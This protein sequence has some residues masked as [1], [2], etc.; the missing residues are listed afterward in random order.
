[1]RL[2]V[3]DLV[4]NPGVRGVVGVRGLEGVSGVRGEGRS[5]AIVTSNADERK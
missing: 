4:L 1:M 3:G 2:I 5:C